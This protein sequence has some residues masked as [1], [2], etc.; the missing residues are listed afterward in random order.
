M[1]LEA[2]EL[3]PAEE[4]SRIMKIR[5]GPKAS[6]LGMFKETNTTILNGVGLGKENLPSDRISNPFWALLNGG[7]EGPRP[8][9]AMKPF[10]GPGGGAAFIDSQLGRLRGGTVTPIRV[11]LFY[12]TLIYI[13]SYLK[14]EALYNVIKPIGYGFKCYSTVMLLRIV[15]NELRGI[16]RS[17]SANTSIKEACKTRF[18]EYDSV[19]SKSKRIKRSALFHS[20]CTNY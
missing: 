14:S 17:I 8:S 5:G 19:T 4:F 18:A 13:Q 7:V 11:Y 15:S 9:W 12:N 20:D 2:R 6:D 10:K 3:N 16:K 1:V